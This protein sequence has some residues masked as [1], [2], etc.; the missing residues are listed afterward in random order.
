MNKAEMRRSRLFRA[1][2]KEFYLHEFEERE[3]QGIRDLVNWLNKS[4]RGAQYNRVCDLIEQIREVR[5]LAHPVTIREFA[6]RE[7]SRNRGTLAVWK[8]IRRINKQLIRYK[9]W[10]R[11]TGLRTRFVSVGARAGILR[12]ARKKIGPLVW[13]WWPEGNFETKAAHQIIRLEEYGLFGALLQCS[14]CDHWFFASTD[15]QKFCSNRCRDKHYRNSPEVRE[16]RARGLRRLRDLEKKRDK[17]ALELI[18]KK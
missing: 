13:Q 15:W 11:Y 4:K 3:R 1:V 6:E 16:K 7:M 2:R 18:K 8:K 12:E 9:V 17:R 5:K 10:P 14:I